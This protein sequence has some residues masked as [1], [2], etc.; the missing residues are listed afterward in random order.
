MLRSRHEVTQVT[1]LY[2]IT[3]LRP[4]SCH[5]LIDPTGCS[6][7]CRAAEFSEQSVLTLSARRSSA[8]S[9]PSRRFS[10]YTSPPR[11]FIARS[12]IARPRPLPPRRLVAASV[13]SVANLRQFLLGY[14]RPAI[15]NDDGDAVC[16]GTHQAA[17]HAVSPRMQGGILQEVPRRKC[18]QRRIDRKADAR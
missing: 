8:R 2:S 17:H 11:R 18:E 16:L 9:P 10:R 1:N 13:K 6:R 3:P 12:A 4:P 5:E 7:R 15:V 14:A